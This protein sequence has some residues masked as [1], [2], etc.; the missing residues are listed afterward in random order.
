MDSMV[1]ARLVLARAAALLGG[2]DKLAGRLEVTQRELG[3]FLTGGA[4]V[5]DALFL[6][7]IDIVLE[8]V[9]DPRAQARVVAAPASQPAVK[10]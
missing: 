6:A 3:D 7:A 2:V 10:D 5:P 8:D 9:P 1:T 4:P